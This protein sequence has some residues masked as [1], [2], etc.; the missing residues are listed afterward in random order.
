MAIW[1]DD[2]MW[3]VIV[4]DGPIAVRDEHWNQAIWEMVAAD[5]YDD[6]E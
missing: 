2:D 1:D 4:A 6:A 5:L 3:A